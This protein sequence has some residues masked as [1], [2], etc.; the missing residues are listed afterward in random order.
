MIY[1]P[2]SILA[3][4]KA[5]QANLS[6]IEFAAS[7]ERVFSGDWL[8]SMSVKVATDLAAKDMRALRRILTDLARKS[9]G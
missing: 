3:L 9:D 2:A 4:V 6:T 5:I 8:T 7:Q 1:D